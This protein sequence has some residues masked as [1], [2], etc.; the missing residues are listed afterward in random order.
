LKMYRPVCQTWR[1]LIYYWF[2][3]GGW[4]IDG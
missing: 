4:M 1:I 3:A 2:I